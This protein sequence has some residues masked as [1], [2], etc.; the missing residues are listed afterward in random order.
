MEM[1]EYLNVFMDECQEHLQTLNQ[2]LLDLESNPDDRQLLDVI[3]RAAHTL[4]GASAT[5]GFNKMASLT[6]AMEDVLSLLR[7][8]EMEITPNIVNVLFDCFDLLEA[9]AQGI[10]EGKEGDIDIAGLLSQLKLIS[11]GRVDM[12]PVK[13]TVRPKKQEIVYSGA[14]KEIILQALENGG[15]FYHI[16][17][18]LSDDCLLKGARAFMVIREVEK[19]GEL[20]KSFPTLK[21]LE[22]ENFDQD[23]TIALI[24][25]KDNKTISE[26]VLSVLDVA[27]VNVTLIDRQKL[28]EM[29]EEVEK[30]EEEAED[31]SFAAGVTALKTRMTRASSSQTVRVEIKKLD[32]LMNLVGELVINRARM[33]QVGYSLNSKALNEVLESIGRITMELRDQVLRTRMV[34]L[35][36]VFSRF[37]RLVRDLAKELGKEV[38]LHITGGETEVDR[39]VIDEIGD[40]LMHLLRNCVDHGLEE[41][42]YRTSHGKP[43]TGII[44]IVAYQEGNSVVIQV[45]DDGRG[46]DL[47]KIRQKAI[48]KRLI[49]KEKASELSNREIIDFVFLPGFSTAEKVT[50]VSGRGVGLDVVKKKIESLGG[51]VDVDTEPHIGTIFQIRLPLTLAI[52]QTLLVKVGDET[53][54]IPSSYIEQTISIFQKDIRMMR[55]HEVT[56]IRG[57]ILPLIR[58]DQ[59]LDTKNA[60]NHTLAELDVVVIQ[61]GER[62]IGLVVDALIKQ[63][64][65]VIKPIGKYLSGIR[66]I[67]GATILGDGKVALILDIRNVA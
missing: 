40:P 32:D 47:E 27:K 26:T 45:E 14:E 24:S 60:I 56:T 9:L 36:N 55:G 44:N 59:F 64:Y 20:V 25:T 12:S 33:E 6:H 39:T 18:K 66:G 49:S 3:F 51:T 34:P 48:E 52:I 46:L 30:E 21:D 35:D 43:R 19:I 2:A 53:Y 22:D 41:P 13:E 65:I 38:E 15:N 16:D 62:R 54:A 29:T 23:F 7:N 63:Q 31:K 37:P 50:D 17:V 58:L 57:E 67:A 61:I 11:A 8:G 1:S 10:V 28:E 4:K 5:M 42:K